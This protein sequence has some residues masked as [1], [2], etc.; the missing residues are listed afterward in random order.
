V[1]C[2]RLFVQVL[3]VLMVYCLWLCLMLAML[4]FGVKCTLS[5]LLYVHAWPLCNP[6]CLVGVRSDSCLTSTVARWPSCVIRQT[7]RDAPTSTSCSCIRRH[8]H[9]SSGNPQ[10]CLLQSCYSHVTDMLQSCYSHVTI[11][12]ILWCLIN[13]IH[14]IILYSNYPFM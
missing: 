3:F 13:V 8:N 11:T 9:R 2:V 1:I 6:P 5:S 7:R 12:S 4:P 10:V 14:V